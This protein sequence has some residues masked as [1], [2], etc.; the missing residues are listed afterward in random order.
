MSSD[1]TTLN[2][3]RNFAATAPFN[4]W[5]DMQVVSSVEGKV[6]LRLDWREDF[7][8]YNGFLHAGI[9]GGLI[10]T[11]AGFAAVTKIGP[12]LVSHY[13]VNMMRP[14]IGDYF[15][16][17]GEVVQTGRKQTFTRAEIFA[18]KDGQQKLVATGDVIVVPTSA[19]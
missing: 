10:D 12:A 19:D 18:L 7:A 1:L 14:A 2:D 3:L 15:I 4:Q 16:A 9:I 17:Y 11:A 8:Q 5:L 13:S 6:E